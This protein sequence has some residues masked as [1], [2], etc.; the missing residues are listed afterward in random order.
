MELWGSKDKERFSKSSTTWINYSIFSYV[1]I[2]CFPRLKQ[3]NCLYLLHTWFIS[4]Q[5]DKVISIKY[6][7]LFQFFHYT[8]IFAD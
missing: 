7:L 4:L 1:V 3:I 5:N 6:A 2:S 8:M